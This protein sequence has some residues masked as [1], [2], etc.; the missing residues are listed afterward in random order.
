MLDYIATVYQ[1]IPLDELTL[2]RTPGDYLLFL[3]RIHPGKGATEAI[4]VARHSNRR[5]IL[6]RINQNQ[7][8]LAR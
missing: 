7:A 4:E 3:G 8:Y 1:S 2:R 5:L 6:A